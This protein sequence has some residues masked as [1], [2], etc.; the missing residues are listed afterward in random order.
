MSNIIVNENYVA[1]GLDI[2]CIEGMAFIGS[3][4]LLFM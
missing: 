3:F 1:V 2:S 4:Y